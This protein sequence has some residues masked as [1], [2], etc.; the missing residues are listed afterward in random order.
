MPNKIK[1]FAWRV[2]NDSLPTMANLYHRHI[3]TIEICSACQAQPED[4]LHA[5][6]SCTKLDLFW[7]SL[8]WFLHFANA[9]LPS[10]Q[11]LLDRFMQFRD[12]YRSEIFIIIAWMLWNC[13]NALRLNLSVQPLNRIC[14][15]DG[16]YLQEFL[17]S[18]NSTPTATVTSLSQQWRLF[19]A[20]KFKA[21][22]NA[23]VFK[24]CNRAS[25]GVIIRDWRGEAIGAL[26]MPV[27]LAQ[28][29]VELEAFA[30]RRAM[31]FAVELG[32]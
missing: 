13:R 22:F 9:H 8:S 5:L 12:D 31:K 16:S 6:W 20:Q 27:P 30:C 3:S 26:S 21:N 24:S 32:L 4:T 19:D 29:L 2:C 15:L 10:F 18:L 7:S 17:D 14:F 11:D 28:I 1:H 25:L 23:T